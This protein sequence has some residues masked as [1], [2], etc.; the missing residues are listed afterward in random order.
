MTVPANQP[1]NNA[2]S[3]IRVV[4]ITRESVE[5]FKILKFEGLVASGG[6]AKMAVAAGQVLVNGKTEIQKRK[7]IVDG[8]TIEFNNEKFDIKFVSAV[9]AEAPA[10][11]PLSKTPDSMAS[12]DSALETEGEKE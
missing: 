1:D 10:E 2:S 5:L 3:N 12:S 9:I 11:A 4:E 6:Q 7:K 8:D